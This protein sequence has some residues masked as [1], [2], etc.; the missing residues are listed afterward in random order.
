MDVDES[1]VKPAPGLKLL[2]EKPYTN[3]AG[4]HAPVVLNIGHGGENVYQPCVQ[5]YS[6][7]VPGQ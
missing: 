7:R 5:M 6:R 4:E 3:E 2:L 1:E